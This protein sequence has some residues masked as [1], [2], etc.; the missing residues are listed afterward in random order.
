MLMKL[1]LS[2]QI[3]EKKKKY[4]NTKFHENP[5][6][7]SRVVPCWQKDGGIDTT[8][9]I[10]KKK[11]N[12]SLYRS[13]VPRGFQEVKAPRLRD[14][15]SGCQPYAPTTFYPQKILLVLISV[16]GWVDPRAKVRSEGLCQWKIPMTPSG[17]ETATFRFVA[18]HLNHCVTAVPISLCMFSFYQL[19]NISPITDPRCP[20]ISRNFRFPDYVTVTQ[21]GSKVVSLTHWPLLPP[22]NTPGTHFC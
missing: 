2:G 17:I 19:L 13:E 16:R 12:L 7:G 18:Q 6:S 20:E 1:E 10:V 8:N 22:G 3:F 5:F 4:L 9:L 11:V 14:N 15:G 21:D